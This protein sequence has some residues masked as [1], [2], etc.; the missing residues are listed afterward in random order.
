MAK[1]RFLVSISRVLPF[2]AR[3]WIALVTKGNFWIVIGGVALM[4]AA[5][6]KEFALDRRAINVT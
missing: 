1:R 4:I 6:G 2:L 3:V 5:E